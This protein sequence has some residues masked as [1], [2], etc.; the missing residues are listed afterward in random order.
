[1]HYIAKGSIHCTDS[2]EY[3]EGGEQGSY[4]EDIEPNN[5]EL[6][7]AL[8]DLVVNFLSMTTGQSPFEKKQFHF[9]DFM[10]W[11]WKTKKEAEEVTEQRTT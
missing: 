11:F 1:M 6:K 5:E 8:W 9:P 3:S 7:G 2:Q 4:E 10:M